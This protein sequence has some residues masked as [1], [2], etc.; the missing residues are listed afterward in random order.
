[1]TKDLVDPPDT[2][3]DIYRDAD[4]GEQEEFDARLAL[5]TVEYGEYV[6]RHR[7]PDED[8]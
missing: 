2:S 1:M 4:T 5:H 7:H 8:E 6:G 3:G